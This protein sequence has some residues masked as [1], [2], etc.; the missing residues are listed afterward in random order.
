M[1]DD[2]MFEDFFLYDEFISTTVTCPWCETRFEL[3]VKEG[4]TDARYQC[5]DCRNVFSIDW[6]A[7]T[8]QRLSDRP[9]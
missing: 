9:G 3:D 8:T 5:A 6:V 2:D 4:E 7:R 1:F